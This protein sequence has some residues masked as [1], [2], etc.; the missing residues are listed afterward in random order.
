LQ[1]ADEQRQ[2][3]LWQMMEQGFNCPL[4]SSCG[5]FFD[6]IAALL[7]VCLTADYEG[8]AAM[9]LESLAGQAKGGQ[10]LEELLRDCSWEIETVY[11]HNRLILQQDALVQE[12]LDQL[13]DGREKAAIA[14]DFHLCLIR[15]LFQLLC[16]LA[17]TTG[18]TQV[19]LT[20]GCMQNTLL[21]E[22]LL[23][24]LEQKGFIVKTGGQIPVNDGGIALGQAI[25]GG[26]R[27]VSGSTYESN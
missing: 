12:V 22:G 7:G 4:T 6:G 11:L 15:S 10:D 26:L 21:L 3:S 9:E 5:R 19:V 24:L 27:H 13:A 23:I 25:I 8:Q 16:K 1:L 20:G 17:E 18:I 14:L 2:R